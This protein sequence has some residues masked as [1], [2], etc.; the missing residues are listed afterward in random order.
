MARLNSYLATT[1]TFATKVHHTISSM[2]KNL[3]TRLSFL[4]AFFGNLTLKQKLILIMVGLS[5][6]LLSSLLFLYYQAEKI[7]YRNLEDQIADLSKIIQ[8]GV[9]EVTG[10]SDEKR[11]MEYLNKLKSK[12]IKEVSIISNTDEI[13][14]ST[15]PEK[16]GSD[17]NPRK[18][19]MIIRAELG[20][21]VTAEGKTYNVII[22][23]I[24]NNEHYGYLHLKINTDDFSK[25][26]KINLYKRIIVTIAI[27]G[28]GIVVIV[29]LSSH[30][31]RPV[32]DLIVAVRKI[33]AGDFNYHLSVRSNDEIGELSKSINSMVKV[34]E[35][36]QRLQ[37]SLRKAEHLATAGQLAREFAHEVRNP[38]NFINLTIDHV[39]SK[40]ISLDCYFATNSEGN[41]SFNKEIQLLD[42]VKKEI[43]RLD[44]LVNSFLEYAR[45]LT[46]KK[47]KIDLKTLMED[48]VELVK[49]KAEFMG[50]RIISEYSE[51]EVT[52]E[53]DPDLLKTA[54]INIINNS[55]QAMPDGGLLSIKVWCD[56]RNVFVEIADTGSGIPSD[57]IER[58]FEPF[59]TTK[60]KGIGLGLSTTKRIIEEHGGNISLRSTEG[61]GT[62]VT[63]S[64]RTVTSPPKEG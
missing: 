7:L 18:K 15:N 10:A 55:F 17:I 43:H 21:P 53:A 63:F 32:Q 49:A 5:F 3:R 37:E 13:L 60:E 48:V 57:K 62:L 45:P 24:T 51:G 46:V 1:V 16:I 47:Q 26:L 54:V 9:E 22:P 23:V 2:I 41:N 6:I 4:Y 44:G 35:R 40:L 30:Y 42:T 20:E 64:L 59:F 12:G 25:M 52:I 50:I 11:L 19:E 29:F 39:R 31:T 28:I 61:K 36:E 34:L 38:L 33:M 14:A 8:V 27:F 58:V 56:H